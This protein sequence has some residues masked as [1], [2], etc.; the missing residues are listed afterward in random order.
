MAGKPG[1][2]RAGGV[3]PGVA[4]DPLIDDDDASLAGVPIEWFTVEHTTREL[5]CI[6]TLVVTRMIATGEI[7]SEIR[8]RVEGAEPERMVHRSEIERV[9]L[10]LP[11]PPLTDAIPRS[12]RVVGPE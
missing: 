6:D 9:L 10:S 11:L 5:S 3:V 7:A 1:L 4:Y 12:R 2:I 8:I